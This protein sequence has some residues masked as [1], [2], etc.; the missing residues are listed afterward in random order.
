[1][2]VTLAAN[3]SALPA[4]G[5]PGVRAQ[6][7]RRML[8]VAAAVL[9][10]ALLGLL[11]WLSGR[12][13][14]AQMQSRLER[15]A[16]DAVQDVQTGLARTSGRLLALDMASLEAWSRDARRVLAEH[17]ELLSAERRDG[18]LRIRA[19][20]ESPLA[21]Q[22]RFTQEL[23]AEQA[24][25]VDLACTQARRLKRPAYAPSNFVPFDDGA[26][27][28]T[29]EW[30]AP[31]GQGGEVLVAT[32]SLKG[33]LTQYVNPGVA[34]AS[35]LGFSEP[36]GTRLAHQSAARRGS[37]AFVAQQ[38]LDLPGV[39]LVLRLEGWRAV[40]D[41]F[42]N[43]LTALVTLLSVA[44]VSVL[45][46][47]AKDATRRLRAEKSLGEVLAFR[48]AMEDSLVTG[49]R[50]RDLHGR[51]TYV[52]PAFC[53]MVGREPPQ[54]LG[55]HHP[56]PYWPPELASENALRLNGRQAA[57]GDADGF[58]SVYLRSDGTRFPV[59]I[60]EA[61]LIDAR[62][63][64]T[65]WMS[66]VVDLTEKRRV[67]E[68]SRASQERLAASSRLA[69]VGEMASFISHEL[70]QP[71]AAIASYAEGSLNLVRSGGATVADMSEPLSRMAE[72]AERAGRV[73]K[74]VQDAVRRR[75]VGR[76]AVAPRA[77]F[78]AILPLVTLQA[79][80]LGVAVECQVEEG[81]PAVW[82]ERAMVEQVLLNLARN[83]VQ[84]MEG[85]P[86]GQRRLRLAASRCGAG[87][88]VQF[89]VADAGPGIAPDVAERLF[90]PFFTTKAE[91]MGLGLSLCRTVLEQHGATLWHQAA[92]PCGTVFAFRLAHGN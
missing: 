27:Q 73:I 64:Q 14:A 35:D 44:L 15:D 84:A 1:V 62:G 34:R 91:G 41:L 79:R 4:A 82:C 9:V 25:Y 42:P 5:S 89:S 63:Q 43:L 81:A 56:Q 46:L 36:D 22:P 48:K 86:V 68:L 80:R 83:G 88:G 75:A 74:S 3:E 76:E 70:N 49:L 66:S 92:E 67:E 31:L 18:A 32:Y 24:L 78:D 71:L 13:E 59:L 17:P 33:L 30:C 69:T 16:A 38:L 55:E 7:R 87:A 37:R 26:G 6:R 40:P 65:G 60:H 20:V 11:I 39:T 57:D 12:H 47:L 45:A 90:T 10:T 54:L 50:A 77:L 21:G 2:S 58:E 61:P 52:N 19:A 53:R 8:W 28:E 23:R 72:Q 51:T 85:T 29:M